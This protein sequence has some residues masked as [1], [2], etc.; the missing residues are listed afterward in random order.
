MEDIYEESKNTE[1]NKIPTN[2]KQE[3]NA[4][5]KALIFEYKKAIAKFKRH[6][7]RIDLLDERYLLEEEKEIIKEK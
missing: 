5:T 3:Y 2:E 4:R 6:M 1:E 7:N